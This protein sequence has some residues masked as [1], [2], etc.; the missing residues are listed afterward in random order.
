VLDS[1]KRVFGEA[2]TPEAAVARL[3]AD[4]RARGDAALREWTARIDGVTLAAP[5][6]P[7]AEWEAAY[8]ALDAD[9]RDALETSAARVRDFHARQPIPI[10]RRTRWAECSAN[11]SSRWRGWGLRAGRHRAPPSSLLM[12]AIPHAW[13]AW[14][15]S[16]S[17][18][19]G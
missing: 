17:V 9:L 4:V 1:I 6:V 5:E 16:W 18:P 13:P 11:A 8:H 10:G 14:T 12:A 19:G 3:L 2:L 15:K 7:Q